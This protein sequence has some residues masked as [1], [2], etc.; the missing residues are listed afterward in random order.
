MGVKLRHPESWIIGDLPNK[1]KGVKGIKFD[2]P[3]GDPMTSFSI[4]IKP[5]GFPSGF[6]AANEN[7]RLFDEHRILQSTIDGLR[8]A[9]PD[10]V[11]MG[12]DYVPTVGERAT[13]R[14]SGIPNLPSTEY[15]GAFLIGIDPNSSRIYGF[16]YTADGLN[17]ILHCGR[18]LKRC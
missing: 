4:Q 11:V 18:R 7:R 10:F 14:F 9:L 16:E 8:P 3:D 13:Y 1:E 6:Y 5:T 17:I 15:I 12:F 2:I